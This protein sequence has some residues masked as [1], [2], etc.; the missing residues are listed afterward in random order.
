MFVEVTLG[1][2]VSKSA[3]CFF[4]IPLWLGSSFAQHCYNDQL[5]NPFHIEGVLP[6]VQNHIK[7]STC[8]KSVSS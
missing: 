8:C 4:C 3:A 2:H 5:K 1:R 6:V 7:E